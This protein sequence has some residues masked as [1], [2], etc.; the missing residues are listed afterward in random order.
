MGDCELCEVC[1][2]YKGVGK[3][4]IIKTKN[5]NLELNEELTL[6][7]KSSVLSSSFK[8]ALSRYLAALLSKPV[9]W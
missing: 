9:E 1:F 3:T 5:G 6:D 7:I 4:A 2:I 8:G